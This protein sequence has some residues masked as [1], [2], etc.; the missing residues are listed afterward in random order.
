[1]TVITVCGCQGGS[2]TSD[3]DFPSSTPDYTKPEKL[4][5]QMST[6]TNLAKGEVEMPGNNLPVEVRVG[7]ALDMNHM[8]ASN[9]PQPDQ[10]ALVA[11]VTGEDL[12]SGITKIRIAGVLRVCSSSGTEL[13][14]QGNKVYWSKDYTGGQQ[15]QPGTSIKIPK[16][17]VETATIP[18]FPLMHPNGNAGETG[19]FS[20]F[21]EAT[22]GKGQIVFTRALHY[23]VAPPNSTNGCPLR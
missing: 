21:L 1:M 3:V 2:G 20:F 5:L 17:F 23:G 10:R 15:P 6:P 9:P 11:N 22:N 4:W 12:E 7:P 8:D 14:Y 13:A 19:E 16:K 18:L